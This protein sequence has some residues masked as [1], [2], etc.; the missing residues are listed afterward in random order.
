MKQTPKI[1]STKRKETSKQFPWPPN[2]TIYLSPHPRPSISIAARSTAIPWIESKPPVLSLPSLP[3][4]LEM[5]RNGSISGHQGQ[6]EQLCISRRL[7]PFFSSMF[8]PCIPVFSTK[9]C[10]HQLC[11]V[12][13][14]ETHH[15]S[16]NCRFSRL[17][18]TTS[19]YNPSSSSRFRINGRRYETRRPH[20]ENPFP[21]PPR[22]QAPQAASA[23][24][25]DGVCLFLAKEAK[26][27]KRTLMS[28]CPR[29]VVPLSS[30]WG[31]RG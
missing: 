28:V 29:G 6:A 21:S 11:S 14:P 16:S 23:T 20:E 27:A 13:D 3:R 15:T 22:S 10:R 8:L 26:E 19:Q 24:K 30:A 4:Y 25:Q 31:R 7:F 1:Y 9:P 5:L 17:P 2:L 12:Q 18:Q